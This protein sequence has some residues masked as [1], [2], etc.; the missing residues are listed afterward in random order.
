MHFDVISCFKHKYFSRI[1]TLLEGNSTVLAVRS[2][3]NQKIPSIE[4]VNVPS[5]NKLVCFRQFEKCKSPKFSRRACPQTLDEVIL[6]LFSKQTHT[7][8]KHKLEN[9][10]LGKSESSS[11][12]VSC[13]QV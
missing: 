6:H 11:I 10:A 8:E 4:E 7:L 2:A 9:S 13:K 12:H 5:F 3:Y 1:S